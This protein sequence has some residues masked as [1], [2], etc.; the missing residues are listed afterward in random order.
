M[1]TPKMSKSSIVK[2][3][4][5]KEQ[6]RAALTRKNKEERAQIEQHIEELKKRLLDPQDFEDYRASSQEL[7]DTEKY[8]DFLNRRSTALSTSV[9]SEE[10]YKE[11]RDYLFGEVKTIQEQAA[12]KI[13][14]KLMELIDLMD[15]YTEDIKE[16]ETVINQALRMHAQKFPGSVHPAGEIVKINPDA[17]GWF[18]KFVYMYYTHCDTANAIKAGKRPNVWGR[19]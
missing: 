15:I 8:L 5:E 12:P 2:T 13:Y 18:A 11:M 19:Y 14:A 3:L 1:R 16:Y 6:E 7:K 9:L 4:E 17:C 10:E